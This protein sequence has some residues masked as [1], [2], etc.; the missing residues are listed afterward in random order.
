[1][2]EKI[3]ENEEKTDLPLIEGI[4]KPAAYSGL[5]FNVDSQGNILPTSSLLSTYSE[6]GLIW[7][8]MTV[9]PSFESLAGW[10]QSVAGNGSI[11]VFVGIARLIPGDLSGNTSTMA[12]DWGPIG[13]NSDVDPDMQCFAL[14]GAE[15]PPT[16]GG[17]SFVGF[18]NLN[19][20]SSTASY[21]GF[22]LLDLDDTLTAV[23]SKA[24][25]ENT[26]TINGIGSDVFHFY[27]IRIHDARKVVEFYID[28]VLQATIPYNGIL[29][30]S[31]IGPVFSIRAVGVSSAA[32]MVVGGLF[33]SRDFK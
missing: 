16:F 18:G 29:L 15:G 12:M 3:Y 32:S 33:F 22:R 17:D 24:G 31:D 30:D 14:L 21:I 25:V 27:R 5:P 4:G 1:M 19:P 8:R 23:V 26:V 11:S 10:W 13:V 6:Q 7:K 9:M 20:W 2:S 28:G